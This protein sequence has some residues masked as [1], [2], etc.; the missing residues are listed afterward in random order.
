MKTSNISVVTFGKL[1]KGWYLVV[2]NK[3]AVKAYGS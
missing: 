2:I 1:N 3:V